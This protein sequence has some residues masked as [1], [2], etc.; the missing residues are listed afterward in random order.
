MQRI[1]LIISIFLL[2]YANSANSENVRDTSQIWTLLQKSEQYYNIHID[3]VGIMVN[4]ALSLSQEMDY[5]NNQLIETI[6]LPNK[7]DRVR[8]GL[9]IGICSF[10]HQKNMAFFAGANISLHTFAH[11]EMNIFQADKHSIGYKFYDEFTE[12]SEYSFECKPETTYYMFSDGFP[13]QFGGENNRKYG[14]KKFRKL[15]IENYTKSMHSQKQL[16]NKELEVWQQNQSQVDDIIIV[17]I[18][19]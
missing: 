6:H 5:I 19:Y 8:D 4:Q 12:Y 11:E 9:D 2:I 16:F 15:L 14:M 17:G 18:K 3:S 10:Y 7:K 1:K 13:D